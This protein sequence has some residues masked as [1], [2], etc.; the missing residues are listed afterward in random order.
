MVD[1]SAAG[2][3]WQPTSLPCAGNRL[4]F[5]ILIDD[6]DVEEIAERLLQ[7]VA[8]S[9]LVN[10]TPQMSAW[11]LAPY[12]TVV[13]G[14]I[15]EGSLTFWLL[16]AGVNSERWNGQAGAAKTNGVAGLPKTPTPPE[17]R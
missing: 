4:R 6:C 13:T 9:V 12:N 11:V 14:F 8:D 15:G 5:E 16:L 2:R 10:R 1:P 3:S 17:G 7:T